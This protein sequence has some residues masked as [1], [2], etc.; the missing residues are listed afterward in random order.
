MSTYICILCTTKTAN[1]VRYNHAQHTV[2]RRKKKGK[3]IRPRA[4][5]KQ[6]Y[7]IS[8]NL[9]DACRTMGMLIVYFHSQVLCVH[10]SH[11][12]K[13]ETLCVDIYY[14]V[15]NAD[16]Q[17][18]YEEN[19]RKKKTFLCVHQ[20]GVF[21]ITLTAHTH[22]PNIKKERKKKEYTNVLLV[23]F[24]MIETIPLTLLNVIL[25]NINIHLLYDGFVLCPFNAIGWE[26]NP[27]R[28]YTTFFLLLYL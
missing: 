6:I 20:R 7:F 24:P 22:N 3:I 14:S 26:R 16:G 27:N 2:H 13:S 19:K 17:I 1:I 12:E 5:T 21:A 4:A 9:K 8:K 25:K 18:L 28:I 11:C 15:S 23:V 10:T